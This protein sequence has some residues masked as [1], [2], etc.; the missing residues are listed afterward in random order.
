[1]QHKLTLSWLE[2]FLEEACESLRGNMDASEYKE[3]IIAILFLKRINDKFDEERNAR[4]TDFEVRGI[5]EP[6]IKYALENKDAYSFYIPESARWD[7]IKTLHED[8]GE[9]L[10]IAF[11]ALEEENTGKIEQGVLTTIDFNKPVGKN[12][13]ISDEDLKL[14]IQEFSKISFTDSNLEFPDLLGAAYEYLIKYFADSSG[15]KGG[16]FYTPNEVVRLLVNLMQPEPNHEIY[17]PT[18]G[19]GGFLI[20]AHNYVKSRYG[21]D[22]N[23]SLFGQEKNGTTWSLCQMNFLFHGIFDAEIKNGDT[24]LDPLHL[25]GGVLRTFDIVLA[26]PPFSQNWSS[27]SMKHKDRFNFDMPKKGK[28]DFM[29]VQHMIKSLK[30]NGRMAVVMPHG[31][32]FRGGEEKNMR[33]WLIDKGYLEAV[34]SLPTALFYGTGIPAAVLI[35]N[36]KNA[37]DR[38]QVLFINADKEFKEGKVQNKLRSEDIEKIS[39][40]YNNKIIIP[41]YSMLV[42]KKELEQEEFNLN[43]RRYVDN[44]P[45]P[46]PHDVKAHLHGGIPKTEVDSLDKYFFNYAGLKNKLFCFSVELSDKESK[47]IIFKESIASK[48]QIKKLLDGSQ[49]IKAKHKI[50]SQFLDSWWKLNLPQ[51]QALPE[52]KNVFELAQ[53]F[54]TSI[55]DEMEKLGILDI[56]QCRGAFANF[57]NSLETDLKSVAASGWNPELIPEEEILQSQFPE[58]LQELHEME[59][60]RDELE[61]MFKEVNE[62]DEGSYNEE[63]YEVLPKEILTEYKD[64]I[65][66]ISSKHKELIK[67]LSLLNKRYIANA[68]ALLKS[69]NDKSFL[70]LIKGELKKGFNKNL[71]DIIVQIETLSP[72]LEDTIVKRAEPEKHLERHLELEKELRECKKVINEIK[73]KKD[74]LVAKAREKITS[75]EAKALIVTRWQK[76]LTTT[77]EDYLSQYQRK[78]VISIEKLW[79]KYTIPLHQI[80]SLVKKK[81]RS[82]IT[83]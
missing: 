36:K 67:E 46:E 11:E 62:L 27:E 18:V 51:L 73:N 83:F 30:S 1:M 64:R 13:R 74:D 6:K 52:N 75:E 2:Y 26:N 71:D 5:S 15:K 81:L 69:S 23:I 17:D 79:E 24:L 45:L 48:E 22:K 3:Y 16:E 50:Y 12:K 25:Q 10:R 66:E 38:D 53:L 7:E 54:T 21:L 20:Q 49:E 31:V 42:S 82:L 65:K 35:I 39:Y 63:D 14:L 70:P 41:A 37:S 76:T 33:K 4:Q 19:S 57:W 44:S 60:R 58:V 43:I 34:I 80:I 55:A 32:L 72:Q 78:F 8:I 9:A 68:K 59:S 28:A 40:V 77:I 61:S 47:Y 56:Y 29:F